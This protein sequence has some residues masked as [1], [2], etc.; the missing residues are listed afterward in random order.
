MANNETYTCSPSKVCLSGSDSELVIPTPWSDESKNEKKEKGWR[1]EFEWKRSLFEIDLT[2]GI[3]AFDLDKGTEGMDDHVPDEIDGGKRGG[4][5]GEWLRHFL[6][7]FATALIDD[8][9]TEDERQCK[10]WVV[11]VL[12]SITNV[13][14][15]KLPLSEFAKSLSSL[16]D[17][18]S[19]K[20]L[21]TQVFYTLREKKIKEDNTKSKNQAKYAALLRKYTALQDEVNEG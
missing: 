19:S 6:R 11:Y 17:I 10:E 5:G 14:D 7:G 1:K 18:L 4:Y 21:K 20:R 3:N 16:E 9:F 2:F 12:S 13:L 15:L 8:A